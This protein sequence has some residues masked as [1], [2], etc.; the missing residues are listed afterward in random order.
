MAVFAGTALGQQ[1]GV[2]VAPGHVDFGE[3]G[4]GSQATDSLTIESARTTNTVFDIVISRDQA[5]WFSV[6]STDAAGRTPTGLSSVQLL[7]GER[8]SIDV[9]VSVPD[10]QA[11]GSYQAALQFVERSTAAATVGLAFEVPVALVVAGERVAA[12]QVVSIETVDVGIG[13]PIEVRA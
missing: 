10:D 3:V 8:H 7:P 9:W 4:P 13:F 1:G 2:G 11:A 6:T 12:G 5:H